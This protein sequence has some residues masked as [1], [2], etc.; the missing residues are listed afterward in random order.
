MS[1]ADTVFEANDT[2]YE[3]LYIMDSGSVDEI[4]HTN[5]SLLQNKIGMD[6]H[7]LCWF[8]T[9]IE[10][11][12]IILTL[13]NTPPPPPMSHPGHFINYESIM[14]MLHDRIKEYPTLQN[15]KILTVLNVQLFIKPQLDMPTGLY[16]VIGYD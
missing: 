9:P 7:L 12:N 5:A 16:R 13:L 11:K 8:V 10:M 6:V 3:L 14:R 2:L 1:E 4:T 15:N